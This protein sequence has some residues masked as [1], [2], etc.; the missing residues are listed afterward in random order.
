MG[1]IEKAL[2]ASKTT[3]YAISYEPADKLKK[4]RESEHLGSSFVF[5]SDPQGK[6]SS[7]YSGKYPQGYLK[8]ATVVVGKKGKIV[9]ATSLEDYRVRPAAQEVVKAIGKGF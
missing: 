1:K 3:V 8:P 6:L 7:H 5:L 4:M 2:A 9:F